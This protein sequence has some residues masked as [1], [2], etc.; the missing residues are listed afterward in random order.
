MRISISKL[1]LCVALSWLSPLAHSQTHA[2]EAGVSGDLEKCATSTKNLY[3]DIDAR[4]RKVTEF[5]E[6]NRSGG[7]KPL[8]Y[9]HQPK[10][11]SLK[12]PG[13]V[14]N[15]QLT[16]ISD[17]KDRSNRSYTRIEASTPFA[18]S[19]WALSFDEA[20]KLCEAGGLPV[21]YTLP[22]W[23]GGKDPKKFTR[24]EGQI[25]LQQDLE[26]LRN[27]IEKIR[28]DSVEG[29]KFDA[30]SVRVN[31]ELKELVSVIAQG[32]RNLSPA[33]AD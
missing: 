12:T 6:N 20:K 31:S 15:G 28:K 29:H 21:V 14:R 16:R 26:L 32:Q 19:R 17:F 27:D 1:S 2:P 24:V 8:R 10:L 9:H 18:T 33:P 13:F 30:G 7:W 25:F 11:L 4:L 23:E 5:M 22:P 3:A